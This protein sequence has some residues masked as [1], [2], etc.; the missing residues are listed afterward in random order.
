MKTN[1]ILIIAILIAT[2]L[3]GCKTRQI[4]QQPTQEQQQINICELTQK[5]HNAQPQFATMNISKL[6]ISI[7]YIFTTPTF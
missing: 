3:A 1:K 4:T 6:N 5:V 2:I 7:D